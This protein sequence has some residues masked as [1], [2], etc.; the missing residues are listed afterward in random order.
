MNAPSNIL[1]SKSCTE[2]PVMLNGWKHHQWFLIDQIRRWANKPVELFP[3]FVAKLKMLGESQFDIY[4]GS[5]STRDI[6]ADITQQLKNFDVYEKDAYLQWI[7]RSTHL[8]WQ[9][10]I[11]D[12]S[13]WTLR[14]GDDTEEYY[15]H[16]HPSRHSKNT[17]RMKANPM[18]TAVSTLIYAAMTGEKPGMH[19]LNKVRK[20]YLGLSALPR[21]MAREI[22]STLNEIAALSGL[23]Q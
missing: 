5:L 8:Y 22:F 7:E 11:S 13:E 3:L 2:A 12:D 18:R 14:Q 23:E 9:V 21:S 20:D 6:A 16:I 15:I 4:T 10:S 19:L 17:R 1:K